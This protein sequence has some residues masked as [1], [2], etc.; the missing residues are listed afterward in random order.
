MIFTTSQPKDFLCSNACSLYLISLM[1]L[2]ASLLCDIDII[3]LH[4]PK[5]HVSLSPFYWFRCGMISHT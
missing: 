2:S 4:I 3:I 1:K 5:Y